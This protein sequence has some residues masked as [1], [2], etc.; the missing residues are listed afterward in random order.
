M[1]LSPA[2]ALMPVHGFS[3]VQTVERGG[4]TI[5][6]WRSATGVLVGSSIAPMD[7]PGAPDRVGDTWCLSV[8]RAGQRATDDEL[9]TVIDGFGM[10]AHEEDNHYP[11][12][13]RTLFCPI[14]EEWR[15]ICD[16]KLTEMVVIDVDGYEWTNPLEGPCRG[17]EMV[18]MRRLARLPPRPCPIHDTMT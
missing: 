1:K 4:V 7:L 3:K 8:S 9:R 17:C 12:I 18:A 11:G 2:G 14:E 6:F 15:G 10:P 13:T 5:S 16:C